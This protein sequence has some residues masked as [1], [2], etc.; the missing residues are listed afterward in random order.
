LGGDSQSPFAP[1]GPP[2]DQRQGIAG[3]SKGNRAMH[4]ILNKNLFLVKGQVGLSGLFRAA[5][6]YD[7]YDPET[8]QVILE[9]RED[10]PGPITKLLRFTG[11]K[12]MTP[13]DIRVRTPAGQQVVRAKRRISVF[14][15]KVSMLDEHDLPIG[16]FKQKLFSFRGGLNL[17]DEHENPVC[18]LKGKWTGWDFRFVFVKGNLEL[19]IVTSRWAGLGKEVFTSA[20]DY[21]LQVTAAVPPN[22]RI[23][24][25]ILATL[26]CIDM[27]RKA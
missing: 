16:G 17:L 6:N 3:R 13:F 2:R 20:H 23:R 10:R 27:V 9:C 22:S 11:W 15:A 18:S 21:V 5:R 8:G 4:E 24:Q 26:M 19:A 25:L 1:A 14:S 12:Q 7:V